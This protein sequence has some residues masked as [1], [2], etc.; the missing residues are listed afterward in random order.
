[1]ANNSTSMKYESI[2]DYIS[3]CNQL[4]SSVEN[5]PK[6]SENAAF[7]LLESLGL[8][9]GFPERLDRQVNEIGSFMSVLSDSCT[10]YLS[11]VSTEDQKG[12][13]SFKPPTG[14]GT[15]TN[16]NGGGSNTNSSG[17]GGSSQ[18]AESS[19]LV[20]DTPNVKGLDNNKE[21]EAS[22]AS[23]EVNDF[24]SLA[25]N[26]FDTIL[27]TLKQ[28]A[29]ENNVNLDELFSEEY[30]DLIKDTLLNS[31]NISQELKDMLYDE[32][33]D[34]SV[35]SSLKSVVEGKVNDFIQDDVMTSTLIDYLSLYA[36]SKNITYD[37]LI[38]LEENYDLLLEG[39]EEFSKVGEVVEVVNEESIQEKLLNIYE[40]NVDDNSQK[41]VIESYV[42][43]L[44]K[45]ENVEYNELLNDETYKETVYESTGDL[46]NAS[47]ATDVLLSCS[48][49]Q[50]IDTLKNIK[51][52]KDMKENG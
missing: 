16:S 1:M 15:Q 28:L 24:T 17:V 34:I 22:I 50:I 5:L 6:A 27:S 37:E 26:D 38:N 3:N 33:S 11:D 41:S 18:S 43:N 48:K 12:R 32:K 30:A 49:E 39:L 4:V 8:C 20:T 23:N 25:N 42:D 14:G 19:S 35:V 52:T 44:S 47:K 21:Q 31:A 7:S 10:N 9:S 2:N 29:T 45:E 36:Q 13:D 51:L 40:S 46:N